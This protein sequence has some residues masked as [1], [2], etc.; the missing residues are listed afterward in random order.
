MMVSNGFSKVSILF[1]FLIHNRK[2]AWFLGEFSRS[3][4][5]KMKQLQSNF[6]YLNSSL[7]KQLSA[8]EL[9]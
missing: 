9:D 1:N 2:N 6:R 7:S 8:L 3:Q 5:L 4:V